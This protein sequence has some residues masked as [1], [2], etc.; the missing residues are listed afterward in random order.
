MSDQ[1][2][3][4]PHCQKKIP[5]NQAL[6]HQ[7]KKQL[8]EELTASQNQELEAFRQEKAKLKEEKTKLAE[9][10]KNLAVK[11]EEQ[12]ELEKKKLWQKA[13]LHAKEQSEKQ[14]KELAEQ[15]SESKKK[16]AES[17]QHELELRK[18][19]RELEERGRKI[20]LELVR[21][22]D[23][24][25]HKLMEQAKKQ[26]DEEHNLKFQESA[27]QMEIMRKTIAD[28]KRQSQQGSMQIQGEVQ[29]DSLKQLL[30]E[31]FSSDE[32]TDVL[33]G[34]KGADLVQVINGRLG[35]MNGRII[36]ESKNTKAFSENW[37]A[38]LKDDQGKVKADVAILVTQTL[39]NDVKE[40]G[41][42]NGV[43]LTSYQFAIPLVS[44]LRFHLIELLKLKQSVVGRDEKM[45]HLYRYLS[46][47]QF[48]NRIENIVMAFMGMRSDLE[49]E[50]RSLQR[51][52]SKR[53]K[54]I[55]KVLLTTSSLYGDLQ[56]I[57]G[58]SLPTIEHLELPEE[59]LELPEELDE[60]AEPDGQL[61]LAEVDSLHD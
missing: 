7:I 5:L 21:R 54:E 17:E 23:E 16:Q 44:A 58:G 39:P 48:K 32:I 33:T 9:Q 50:K 11:L 38:K 53:E 34:A 37:I 28:L 49:T 57:I 51:L 55:E 41:L 8:T 4:C 18:Q 46:G 27:K 1:L 36:W 25:R 20:E 59:Y 26:S 14:V 47:P 30:M 24:E 15:L 40:F 12:L 60:P 61:Q 13:Q 31:Q 19:A 56:G 52:W 22:L 6:S 42:K 35:L 29:E 2:I 43:W 45:S 3:T 10:E